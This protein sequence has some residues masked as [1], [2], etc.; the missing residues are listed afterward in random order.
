MRASPGCLRRYAL[1]H[2]AVVPRELLGPMR[3]PLD[4]PAPA[5]R[6]KGFA[7][8]PSA[9]GCTRLCSGVTRKGLRVTNW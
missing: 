9:I 4:V 3:G 1:K 2:Q 6:A 5:A 7:Q 8:E